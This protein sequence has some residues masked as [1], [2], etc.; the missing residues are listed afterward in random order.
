MLTGKAYAR[1]FRGLLMIKGTLYTL[2]YYMI[3]SAELYQVDEV[4]MKQKRVMV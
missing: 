1:A 3:K 2:I 4:L